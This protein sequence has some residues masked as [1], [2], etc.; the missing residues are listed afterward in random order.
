MAKPKLLFLSQTLPYPPDSG[1]AIRSYNVLRLLARD[2]DVTALCFYRRATTPDL[3]GSLAALRAMVPTVEAFPI[4]QE[5]SRARLV[6]DHA[7][8]LLT[9]RAYTAYAYESASFSDALRTHLERD[10]FELAH[11]DSLDLGAHVPALA[12]IPVIAVHQNVE[13]ALLRRRAANDTSSLRRAYLR[14]QAR[15][16]EGEER[17]WSPRVALN[18]AVS[19]ADAADLRALVPSARFEMIPNGVD[20]E[21][22]VPSNT[23]ADDG[24]VFVGGMSWFPNADA[25][26]LFDEE[27]LPLVRARDP[28]VRVTWVG[29]A[30]PE[31]IA[32]YAKRGITLTGH[33][34]DIRPFVASAACYVVPLRIGGG[35]RLKILDA[36]AMGKAVVSTSV[37]CEGL[38]A[39]DG[40]NILIRDDPA[41]FAAAVTTVL[42]DTGLRAALERNARLTAEQRYSWDVIGETMRRL[43]G[44]VLAKRS[45]ATTAPR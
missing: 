24:I 42:R 35:T 34:D 3:A 19:D 31:A 22:F 7:R 9:G 1:T 17:R 32:S 41:A 36:W 6:W 28:Q 30:K 15:L 27:I 43:Y 8:S 44:E 10:R 40:K 39:V 25:L 12:G 11:L 2:Y 33:V 38:E 37:G 16:M 18:L 45:A 26:E 5:H 23:A 4:E 29:R 20:V 13:S 14:V 21:T